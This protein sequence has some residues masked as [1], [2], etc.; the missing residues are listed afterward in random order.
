M[1]LM[2]FQRILL[3]DILDSALQIATCFKIV[4]TGTSLTALNSTLYTRKKKNSRVS[5][6]TPALPF[7][8]LNWLIVD[9]CRLDFYSQR[10]SVAYRTIHGGGKVMPQSDA[11]QENVK[12]SD[13]QN[14]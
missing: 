13:Q 12:Y 7:Q 5:M 14:F 1:G 10:A 4:R 11:W 6:F 8:G 3:K 2:A 9:Y